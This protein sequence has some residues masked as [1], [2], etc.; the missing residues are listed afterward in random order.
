MF[1]LIKNVGCWLL[2][3]RYF[4]NLKMRTL[5]AWSLLGQKVLIM[6]LYWLVNSEL[7]FH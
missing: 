2:D 5:E 3:E 6:V 7:A 1:L 4:K